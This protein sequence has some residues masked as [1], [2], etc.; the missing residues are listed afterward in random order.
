MGKSPC[1]R[2][3]LEGLALNGG[4]APRNLWA[5]LST[6]S[7]IPNPSLSP[8]ELPMKRGRAAGRPAVESPDGRDGWKREEPE[9]LGGPRTEASRARK[10]VADRP[11]RKVRNLRKRS[12]PKALAG[13]GCQNSDPGRKRSGGVLPSRRI[14]DG[15]PPLPGRSRLASSRLNGFTRARVIRKRLNGARTASRE[16]AFAGEGCQ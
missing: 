14:R 1:S 15:C 6:C 9:D 8:H 5:L 13:E 4:G 10:L 7:P 3:W 12:W 2:A 16:R 11:S